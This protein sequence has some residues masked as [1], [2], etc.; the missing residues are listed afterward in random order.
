M[1]SNTWQKVGGTKCGPSPIFPD[2]TIPAYDTHTMARV[3][4]H[5]HQR[6]PMSVINMPDRH[7]QYRTHL[8]DVFH[9]STAYPRSMATA[10]VTPS[11]HCCSPLKHRSFFQ[12]FSA[13]RFD[14]RDYSIILGFNL[15]QSGSCR[16]ACGCCQVST[17]LRNALKG[18]WW[19]SSS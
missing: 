17:W 7:A 12:L 4:V 2:T 13:L 5:P 19:V 3:A 1:V 8:D 18:G 15:C 9:S 16:C 14:M 11:Y 6:H 10:G